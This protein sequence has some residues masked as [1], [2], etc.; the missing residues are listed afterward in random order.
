MSLTKIQG[1]GKLMVWAGIWGDRIIG[2][3]FIDGTLNA[4]RYFKML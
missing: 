3:I 1:A 2:P 4:E